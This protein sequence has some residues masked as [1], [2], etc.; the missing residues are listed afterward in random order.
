MSW[1]GFDYRMLARELATATRYFDDIVSLA[2]DA[3]PNPLLLQELERADAQDQ[4]N[5]GEGWPRA[6]LLNGTLNYSTDIEAFL[7][8]LK[9][10]MRRADRIVAVLY[11]PYFEW[12]YRVASRIGIRTAPV[13]TTFLTL[14]SLRALARLAGF[15]VTRYRPAVYSPFALLG[16]GHLIN[17]VLPAI[18]FVRHFSLAGIAILRPIVPDANAPSLSIVIPARNEAGN[19]SAALDRLPAFEGEVEVIFV[20]GHST[21]GTWDAIERVQREYSGP[22]RVRAFRQNGR[23]KADAVR[24][25][26]SEATGDLLTILDADLTM[27]PELL[28]RFYDAYRRGAADFINGNRLVYPMEGNAMRFLNRLGNIFFAKALSFVLDTRLG[29]SLCGTKLVSRSDYQRLVA[30]RRDFGEFDPFGDFELLFPAAVLGLGI[31]DLPVRYRDRTYGSTNISRFRH[32]FQ[33]LRMTMIGLF[34]IRFGRT[35]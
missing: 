10:R 35:A 24:L 21:D 19:I 7:G 1:R 30:W 33:L 25:G 8:D 2:G 14:T 26:F 13:P 11:N 29:D 28:P 34:R 32:G 22:A 18:P 27:P 9:P 12:L 3:P 16:I 17:A 6:W 20:E 31:V 4:R 23:G 15:E 5:R